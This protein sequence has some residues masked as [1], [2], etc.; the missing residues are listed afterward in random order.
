MTEGK[1][2]LNDLDTSYL[3]LHSKSTVQPPNRLIRGFVGL[4][5]DGKSSV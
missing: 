5:I 4:N 2:L 1:R 3:H